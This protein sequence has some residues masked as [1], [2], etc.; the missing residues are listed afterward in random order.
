MGDLPHSKVMGVEA[1][2]NEVRDGATLGILG[3]G[4]GIL[5]PDLLIRSLGKRFDTTTHPREL[6]LF[7][8]L[9]LGNRTTRGLGEIAR[10]NLIRRVVGG[11]FGQCL[12]MARLVEQELI[13]AYNLPLGVLGLLLREIAG[14]RPGLLTKI[15]L[16]TFVDPRVEGGRLNKRTTENI[17]EVVSLG[18]EEFLFYRAIP[19]DFAFVRGS[20]A[21]PDGNV[22][23]ADEPSYLDSY[24]LAA[25]T[26]ASGGRV[27]VQVEKVVGAN[28]IPPKEVHIPGV[29]VDAVVEHRDQWQTYEAKRNPAFAGQLRIEFAGDQ[30]MPFGPRKVIA[31]RAA[32]ELWPG[33]I[34]NLGIGVPDGI[35]SVLQEE[36]VQDRITFSIEH[37]IFGGVTA[38]GALLGASMNHSAVISLPSMIDFYHSGGLDITCLGFAQ[39]DRLGNVNV[40]K[41]NNT[42]MGS[43]GFIDI[44]QFCPTIILCGTFTAGDLEVQYDKHQFRIVKEG[45]IRKFVQAVDQITF[46]GKRAQ[47]LGQ[48]VIVVTER[49]VFELLPRG[50]TLMEVVEGANVE[51]DILAQMEFAPA[52]ADPLTNVSTEVTTES[53]LGLASRWDLGAQPGTAPRPR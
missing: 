4:G 17:V 41:F 48:R 35:A 12:P 8:T 3:A 39:I 13:E 50:L 2:V 51:S 6:T 42:I 46:N 53:T 37:G 19:I 28:T 44:T 40:S 18:G 33:A 10:S 52:I 29:L 47:S 23:F 21:D 34:V 25:A 43:G 1:C 24:E 14:G 32:C 11:H 27:F 7:H 16:G 15:G 5:E 38:R 26:H 30:A 9:G 36:G 20:Y 31:R 49:A 45:R 22:S